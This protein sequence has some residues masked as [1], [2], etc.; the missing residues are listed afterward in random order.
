MAEEIFGP[1]LP[2]IPVDGFDDAKS[3]IGLHPN[4]LAAYCFTESG[5][6]ERRFVEELSFG[7]GCI[8]DTVIHLGIPNLPFGG[9]QESGIGRYHAAE[10]FRT[11]SNQKSVAKTSTLLNL[12]LRYAPYRDTF[13]RAVKT[14][15]G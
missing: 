14:I 6:T 10:G 1:I 8:N 12:P 13:L 5:E 15:L 7:G 3:I 4:P 11:F 2:V 9:V